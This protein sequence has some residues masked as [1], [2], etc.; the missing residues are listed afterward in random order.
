MRRLAD[1]IETARQ[2]RSVLPWAVVVLASLTATLAFTVVRTQ[3]TPDVRDLLPRRSTALVLDLRPGD[4]AALWRTQPLGVLVRS[5]VERAFAEHG[6]TRTIDPR[7][8][9]SGLAWL[10]RPTGLS[11]VAYCR[12]DPVEGGR[13]IAGLTFVSSDAAA[14]DML[15]P[16]PGSALWDEPA[17]Q[18]AEAALPGGAAL[19]AV[20][21]PALVA[22]LVESLRAPGRDAAALLRSAPA[23]LA[24]LPPIVAVG[25]VSS[26]QAAI[27]IALP[28]RSGLANGPLPLALDASSLSVV[29]PSRLLL[30][31]RELRLPAEVPLLLWPSGRP[32][33]LQAVLQGDRASIALTDERLRLDVWRALGWSGEQP[34]I[35]SQLRAVVRAAETT[36][37]P[38]ALPDGSTAQ[39]LAGPS[40]ADIPIRSAP[41]GWSSAEHGRTSARARS[42]GPQL[43]LAIGGPEVV[44]LAPSELRILRARLRG[45]DLP[46]VLDALV[47]LSPAIKPVAAQLRGAWSRS[48]LQVV[49]CDV[50]AT[51]QADLLRLRWR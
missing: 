45:E 3:R 26:G 40:D 39:E 51:E 23:L 28:H 30:D 7:R 37:R 27:T 36:V 14:L 48:G 34:V 24:S 4:G 11:L 25:H 49:E 17:V 20:A 10:T 46:T 21:Q 6:A 29:T 50:A 42:D 31:P 15:A 13:T 32:P 1:P 19:L 43:T 16:G 41:P 22:P 12:C 2:H 18:S 5:E 9:D 47:R 35:E 33:L 38:L 8:T 44:S